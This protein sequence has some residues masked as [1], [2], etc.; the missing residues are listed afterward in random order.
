MESTSRH[1]SLIRGGNNIGAH[2][3]VQGFRL[4]TRDAKRYRTYFPSLE[5]V[6]PELG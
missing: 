4:L 2:A 3:A 1:L 5:V 6:A